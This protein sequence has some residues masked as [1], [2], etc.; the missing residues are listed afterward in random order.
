MSANAVKKNKLTA[1]QATAHLSL[2]QLK[3]LARGQ[4][5]Y[6]NLNDDNVTLKLT[7]ETVQEE[8]DTLFTEVDKTFKQVS[9]SFK[10]IFGK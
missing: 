7:S 2:E 4:A 8:L 10:K 5:V 6:I 1:R 9:K 3:S